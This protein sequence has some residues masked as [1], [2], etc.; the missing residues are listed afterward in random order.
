MLACDGGVMHLA[1]ALGT[2]TV[3][4]FGSSE[5]EVWFPY[6]GSGPYAAA[7]IDVPCRP[8]HQHV[9]PLG[10]TRCLN[11]L[12]AAQVA[13]QVMQVLKQGRGVA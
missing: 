9:C 13:T 2:P 1:A 7:Y 11:E 3:G 8:C 6:T 10:H 4:I 5:P 12:G